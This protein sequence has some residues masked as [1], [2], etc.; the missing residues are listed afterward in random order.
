[1]W[2]LHVAGAWLVCTRVSLLGTG[3]ASMYTACYVLAGGYYVHLG[4]LCTGMWLVC[5]PGPVMYGCVLVYTRMGLL[6]RACG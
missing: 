5:T 3:V 4:L 6:C 2:E 1:M